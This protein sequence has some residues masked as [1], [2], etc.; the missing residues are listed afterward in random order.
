MKNNLFCILFCVAALP[1]GAQH[2]LGF[3][4]SILQNKIHDCY[5]AGDKRWRDLEPGGYVFFAWDIKQQWYLQTEL[6]FSYRNT[7]IGYSGTSHNISY[8]YR[9]QQLETNILGKFDLHTGKLRLMWLAGISTGMLLG[10]REHEVGY[11]VGN[12][13]ANIYREASLKYFRL[14]R[15]QF[16]PMFGIELARTLGKRGSILFESRMAV[17]PE[18][19]ELHNCSLPHEVRFSFGLGYCWNI[20]KRVSSP[21]PG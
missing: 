19:D 7:R 18:K 9:M 11:A 13:S 5:T 14:R 3:R 4:F 10:G 1:L 20:R 12:Y 17:Y 6:S 8:D 15:F 2:E 21:R 16:G